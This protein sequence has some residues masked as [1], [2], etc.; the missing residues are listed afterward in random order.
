MKC[1]KCGGELRFDPAIQLLK[2]DYCESTFIPSEVNNE[3]VPNA[4][5]HTEQADMTTADAA[6]KDHMADVTSAEDIVTNT[7]IEA[8]DVKKQQEN[9]KDAENPE[10]KLIEYTCPNCGGTLYSVEESV[11]GFCSY[12]GSQV[13]LQSRFSSMK[14][15]KGVIPFKIDKNKC[16]SLYEQHVKKSFFAPKELKDPAYLEQFRGIYMPYHVYNVDL[17]GPIELTGKKEYRRGDYV[18]TESY[19]C[20]VDLDCFFHGLSYDASSSFDDHFSETI[21]PFDAH[22]IVPFEPAYLTGFYADMPDVDAECYAKDVTTFAVDEVYKKVNRGWP[23]GV[24][25]KSDQRGR[26]P[27]HMTPRDIYTSFFPIWFLSYRKGDRVAYAVINGESGKISC[28]MPV[29]TKKFVAFCFLLA[30]PIYLLLALFLPAFNPTSM[31][32]LIQTLGC[33]CAIAMYCNVSAIIT[34]EK[35]LDDRGYMYKYS[36]ND[37]DIMDALKK[38]EEKEQKKKERRDTKASDMIGIIV[39]LVFV[40]G[41]FIFV[42]LCAIGFIGYKVLSTGMLQPLLTAFFVW[43]SFSRAKQLTE[44]AVIYK[45]GIPLLVAAPLALIFSLIAPAADPLFYVSA[46]IIGIGVIIGLISVVGMK[47]LLNTRPL[48][49]LAREGGDANAPV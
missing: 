41:Q 49:Q 44:P 36:Q 12:C 23:A 28:D 24:T 7:G 25:I 16:K 35:R 8:D 26:I 46:A 5:E 45:G 47:N 37:K 6:K 22:S 9:V 4:D 42:A 15:P 43:L 38:K 34:R 32:S 27:V 31:I 39:G 11:N 30:I 10:L 18:Y 21:A 3:A 1:P 13:M 17:K 19:A 2:C 48:P 14:P 33:I 29:N 20:H 40:L